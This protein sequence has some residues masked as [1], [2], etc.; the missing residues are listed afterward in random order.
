M[1]WVGRSLKPQLIPIPRNAQPV[2]VFSLW[3]RP[4]SACWGWAQSGKDLPCPYGCLAPPSCP[5]P[6]PHL[7]PAAPGFPAEGAPK[8]NPQEQQAQGW[9]APTEQL[10]RGDALVG[11]ALLLQLQ[12]RHI[13][14]Q[15]GPG[16]RA[17]AGAAAGVETAEPEGHQQELLQAGHPWNPCS[18]HPRLAPRALQGGG[19]GSCRPPLCH[20]MGCDVTVPLHTALGRDTFPPSPVEIHAV[21]K[22]FIKVRRC[23]K[24]L[25]RFFNK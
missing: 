24:H 5:Y 12:R 7:P 1:V 23:Q 18:G 20:Q 8:E 10:G 17:G 3:P 22:V 6:L 25:S 2:L 16:G 15:G 9:D 11:S 19:D 4:T 14:H 13:P 21:F